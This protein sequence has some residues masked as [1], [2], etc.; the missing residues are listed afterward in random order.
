MPA[1]EHH[2]VIR[3]SGVLDVEVLTSTRDLPCSFEH[4]VDLVEIEVRQEW[5]NHPSLRNATFAM[6]LRISFSS[7]ITFAS[8]TRSAT[9]R[10]TIECDT[11]SK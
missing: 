4:L 5:G 11:V 8:F 3:K 7:R 6:A 9:L 10:K 1:N 2:K